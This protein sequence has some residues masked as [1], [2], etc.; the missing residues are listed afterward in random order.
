MSDDEVTGASKDIFSLLH[1]A[2]TRV[3]ETVLCGWYH[4]GGR[5]EQCLEL[6]L[7]IYYS[8]IVGLLGRFFDLQGLEA[9][10]GLESKI[11]LINLLVDQDDRFANVQKNAL[12]P[13]RLQVSPEP[14]LSRCLNF[15]KLAQWCVRDP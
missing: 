2:E 9:V 11:K 3:R 5:L 1:T 6:M 15:T 4:R 13:F 14:V 7:N 12:R 8:N 10:K